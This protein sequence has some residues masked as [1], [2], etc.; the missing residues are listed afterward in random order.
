MGLGTD[1]AERRC[2]CPCAASKPP[3]RILC[4]VLYRNVHSLEE[5][6]MQEN[7]MTNTGVRPRTRIGITALTLL[8][9]AWADP[10]PARGE[11]MAVHAPRLAFEANRGQ[12]DAQVHFRARGAGYTVFLA[13]DEAVLAL[14]AGPTD[15]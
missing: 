5:T 8:G 6:A 15:S 7:P 12:L 3:A 11:Q 14:R 4:R 13:S 2:Q 9:L 1:D 10:H